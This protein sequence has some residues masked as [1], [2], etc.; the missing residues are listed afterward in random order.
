MNEKILILYPSGAHGNFL[1]FLLNTMAGVEAEYNKEPFNNEIVYDQLVYPFPEQQVFLCNHHV[2]LGNNSSI[3]NIVIEPE[4]Y[5]QYL[6][7]CFSRTSGNN[8]SIEDFDLEKSKQHVTL[9]TFFNSL[10]STDRKDLREWARLSFFDR[11]SITIKM[12]LTPSKAIQPDYCFNF[13]WF[14]DAT[15]L[16]KKCIDICEKFGVAIKN[17]STG[18]YQDFYNKNKYKDIDV[19]PKKIIEAIQ[20]QESLAIH[21]TNFLQEAWIDNWL[22]KNYQIDPLYRDLYFDNTLDIIEQYNLK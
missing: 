12:M 8:L 16:E 10:K 4:S 19:L 1:C 9:K 7:M 11:D 22:A 21:G 6:A 5:L 15:V 17:K 20:N 18:L 14:Y 2:I 3:V 13:E